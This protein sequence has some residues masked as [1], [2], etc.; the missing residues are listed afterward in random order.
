MKKIIVA[1][2]LVSS[3]V[4]VGIAS[5]NWGH[6]VSSQSIGHDRH[7]SSSQPANHGGHMSQGCY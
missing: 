7:A 5:A 3:L 1:A 6:S 2:V 4:L